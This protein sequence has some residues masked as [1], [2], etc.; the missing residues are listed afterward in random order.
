MDATVP[1]WV[2]THA[3]KL[4]IVGKSALLL[5]AM[6]VAPAAHCCT[7]VLQLL[8]VSSRLQTARGSALTAG[9]C[10]AAHRACSEV[11]CKKHQAGSHVRMG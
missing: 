5:R 8:Q 11:T 4:R 10:K 6:C 1:A 2:G 7:A 9:C 3:A